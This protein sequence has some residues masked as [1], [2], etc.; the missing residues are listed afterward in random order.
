MKIIVSMLASLWITL[1]MLSVVLPIILGIYYVFIGSMGGLVLIAVGL[2]V[3]NF[4]Y[5]YSEV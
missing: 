4:V 1:I 5:C 2:F 3:F